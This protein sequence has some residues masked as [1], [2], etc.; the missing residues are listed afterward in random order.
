MSEALQMHDG[1]NCENLGGMPHLSAALQHTGYRVSGAV[2][3]G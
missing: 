3:A 1:S 2:R